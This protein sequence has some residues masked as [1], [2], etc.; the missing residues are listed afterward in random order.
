MTMSWVG[1]VGTVDGGG[2]PA[3]KL[4]CR[5]AVSEQLGPA[6]EQARSQLS[7]PDLPAG[8]PLIVGRTEEADRRIVWALSSEEGA[9]PSLVLTHYMTADA[10]AAALPTNRGTSADRKF[11]LDRQ[12]ELAERPWVLEYTT[13]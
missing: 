12:A 13:F 8:A 11:R 2:P 6:L 5:I 3:G 4:N 9:V 1:R 10:F 7:I